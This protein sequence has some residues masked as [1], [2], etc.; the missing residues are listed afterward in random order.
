[1]SEPHHNPQT[2]ELFEIPPHQAKLHGEPFLDMPS[3]L[4]IPPEALS[5]FLE[6][7]EGPL[8]LLLYLIRK[9]SLDILANIWHTCKPCVPTNSSWRRNIY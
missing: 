7:F 6:A 2:A 3:D 4:F 1:M 9:H 5:V 8:D